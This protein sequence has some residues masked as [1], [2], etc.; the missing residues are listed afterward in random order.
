MGPHGGPRRG[1]S[2]GGDE[3]KRVVV[4]RIAGVFGVRGWVKTISYTAP[5]R[6]IL[7]YSPWILERNGVERQLEPLEGREHG[8]TVVVRL[9]GIIT[10]EEAETLK[11]LSVAVARDRLPPLEAG[12]YYRIDLIGLRV[13]NLE[14]TDFGLIADVLETGANDVLVI[15][16]DRERLVPFVQGEFVKLVDLDEAL[17][18]VDWD[19]DF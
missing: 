3:Q 7:G 10:R 4:G 6:N 9:E 12:E 11:G 1:E 17:V 2:Q 13:R 18:V 19:A 15:R 16:G 5:P 8:D 14:G